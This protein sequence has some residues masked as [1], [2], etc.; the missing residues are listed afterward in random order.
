MQSP[1][2]GTVQPVFNLSAQYVRTLRFSNPGAPGSLIAGFPTPTLH[3][4]ITLGIKRQAEGEFSVELNILA[5]ASRDDVAV[6]ELSMVYGG[7]FQV[8]NY[9]DEQLSAVLSVECPRILFPFARQIVAIT[10]QQAGLPPLIL[11]PVDFVAI[12]RQNLAAYAE[13]LRTAAT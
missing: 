11:A 8:S 5:R 10:A 2:P 1:P 3:N 7:L 13:K 9:P 12:Y 6:F 4:N